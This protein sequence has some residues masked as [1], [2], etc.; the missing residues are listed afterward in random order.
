VVFG[1]KPVK[2]L[3]GRD[4]FAAFGGVDA[5]LDLDDASSTTSAALS[6]RPLSTS[7]RIKSA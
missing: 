4:Q 2:N 7:S 1:L 6:Y 3:F 5:L